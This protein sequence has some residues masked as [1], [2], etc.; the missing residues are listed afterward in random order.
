MQ[1]CIGCDADPAGGALGVGGRVVTSTVLI[2]WPQMFFLNLPG[3][4]ISCLGL[5]IALNVTSRHR[6]ATSHRI[7]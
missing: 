6:P 4:F 1:A 3:V 2:G 7:Y 5:T